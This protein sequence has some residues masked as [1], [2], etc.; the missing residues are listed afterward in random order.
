[1]KII[2]SSTQSYFILF[3]LILCAA[4]C[5]TLPA[6]IGVNLSP[7]S[8]LGADQTYATSWVFLDLMKVCFHFSF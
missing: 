3:A 6:D 1:M 8:P 7:L 2:M 4:Y 5:L